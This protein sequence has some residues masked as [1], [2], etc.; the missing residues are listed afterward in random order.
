MNSDRNTSRRFLTVETFAAPAVEAG[1]ITVTP[2]ARTLTL[3]FGRGVLI[4]SWPAAVLVAR[5]AR[6]SR[7]PI[8]NVAR[9]AGVTIVVATMLCVW[10]LAAG[11]ARRKGRSS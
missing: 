9:L 6:T 8:V 10:G 4:R 2:V 11:A 7:V 1:P 5:E 3:R